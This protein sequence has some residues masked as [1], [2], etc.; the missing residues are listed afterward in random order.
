L[1]AIYTLARGREMQ[2]SG[3]ANAAEVASE[4]KPRPSFLEKKLLRSGAT[5][6]D[7]REREIS[8]TIGPTRQRHNEAAK[9]AGPHS[10]RVRTRGTRYCG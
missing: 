6:S 3:S 5:C 4:M 7:T 10:V 1:S 2:I 9:D 8:L